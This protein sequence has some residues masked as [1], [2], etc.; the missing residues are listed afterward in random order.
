MNQTGTG[1]FRTERRRSSQKE[2]MQLKHLVEETCPGRNLEGG[3]TGYFF[4]N[5]TIYNIKGMLIIENLEIR[6]IIYIERNHDPS[7]QK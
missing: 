2:R 5:I 7:K 3:V 1:G 4:K 6:E